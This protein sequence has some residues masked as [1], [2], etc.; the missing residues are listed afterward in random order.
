MKQ[1]EISF[2]AMFHQFVII[3]VTPPTTSNYSMTY[4]IHDNL[5]VQSLYELSN[6]AWNKPKNKNLLKF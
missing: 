5:K 1:R 4:Q 6:S 3:S 2:N